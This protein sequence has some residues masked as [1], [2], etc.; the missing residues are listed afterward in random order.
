MMT[1]VSYKVLKSNIIKALDPIIEGSM[2]FVVD[3]PKLSDLTEE[4]N[5]LPLN[6]GLES[7]QILPDLIPYLSEYFYDTQLEWID[8]TKFSTVLTFIDTT[9]L[10]RV[11]LDLLDDLKSEETDI[12]RT[13]I[14]AKLVA[15]YPCY[16]ATIVSY[17]NNN[18]KYLGKPS[19]EIS[20]RANKVVIRSSDYQY[21]PKDMS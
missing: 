11:A 7:A 20:C 8:N 3:Y 1:N 21:N 12:D 19:Y 10:D 18:P 9:G 5:L 6:V 16:F 14:V 15:D 17:Q 4:M 2:Q 13:K